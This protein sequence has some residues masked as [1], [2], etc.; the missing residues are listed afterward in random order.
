MAKR[1]DGMP[2][3]TASETGLRNYPGPWK[4][5]LVLV[6]RKC[7][8]RLQHDGGN[9]RLA[10]M[11]KTL[12]K[13]ARRFD[14]ALDLHAVDVPC[15]KMCPKDGVTV[16]TAAQVANHECSIL[17]SLTDVDVLVGSLAHPRDR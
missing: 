1:K 7:Q 17:R 2:E 6:C 9:K 14:D 11:R 13:R 8:K 4:G 3:D 5:E 10:R 16:C 15:L 12:R